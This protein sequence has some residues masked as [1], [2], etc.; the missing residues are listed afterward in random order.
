[1]AVGVTIVAAAAK[2]AFFGHPNVAL[3]DSIF[4]VHRAQNVLAGQYIFTSIT[5]RPFFEFPYAIAL[6]VTALPLWDWF[7][8]ELDRVRL[9]RG[10]AIAADAVVGI[11]MYFALR[12]ARAERGVAVAFALLWPFARSPLGALCTSNLTNLFGQALFGTAMAVVLWM[13]AAGTTRAAALAGVL[14]LLTAAF[15]SHFS[16]I[17]IGIPLAGGMGVLL[18]LAGAGHT[19]RLGAWLLGI[20]IVAGGLSYAV[21]YSHFHPVYRATIDRIVA[22]DGADEERSMAAPL[23]V[24]AARWQRLTLQEFGWPALMAAAAGAVWLVRRGR[25]PA[26]IVIAGWA[27]G[28]LVFAAL[29]IATPVQMRANLA[30]APLVLILASCAIGALADASRLGAAVA[31]GLGLAM[32]WDG[33]TRWTQ[34]LTG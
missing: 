20:V 15:L 3:A 28:W 16:T 1:M 21:Y 13:A 29:G 25:Q 34:C 6:Y 26:S 11:A 27:I 14:T 7:P 24:K 9:L 30:A 31:T 33:F 32:A 10:I 17:S 23:G 8:T 2:L 12:R 19:R 5:P 18:M 4:Q 22:G